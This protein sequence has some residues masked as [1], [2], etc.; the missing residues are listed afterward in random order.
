MEDA[1]GD[2]ELGLNRY[3]C[4]MCRAS[5]NTCFVLNCAHAMCQSQ[6]ATAS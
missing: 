4:E 5:V 1:R 3:I 2:D 6:P